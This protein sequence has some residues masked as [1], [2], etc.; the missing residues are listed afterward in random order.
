[1][2]ELSFSLMD[3]IFYLERTY[4]YLNAGAVAMMTAGGTT[5]VVS[6]W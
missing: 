3:I 1:M 6:A 4:L 2:I 5:F